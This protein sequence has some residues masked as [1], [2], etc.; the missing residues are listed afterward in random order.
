PRI[1]LSE[2]GA[3]E[4]EA[5]FLAGERATHQK[6]GKEIV[7][8]EG[9]RIELNAMTSDQFVDWLQ[10]KLEENGVTKVVPDEATLAPAWQRADRIS[11]IKAAT[12][13][14]EADET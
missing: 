6:E 3:T 10:R 1:I 5:N 4:D 12:A 13:E 7:V 9:E 14:I 8:W 11:R 2:Y